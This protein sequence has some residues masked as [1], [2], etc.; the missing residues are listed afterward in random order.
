[1]RFKKGRSGFSTYVAE[2]PQ[3]IPV[4]ENICDFQYEIVEYLFTPGA[5]EV[6]NK[7]YYVN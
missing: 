6:N 7:F 5:I 4:K 2:I 3:C 1:M